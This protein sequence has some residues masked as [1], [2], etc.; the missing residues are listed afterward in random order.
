MKETKYLQRCWGTLNGTTA[1]SKGRNEV[2]FASK[3]GNNK[4]YKGRGWNPGLYPGGY[5]A[6]SV[7]VEKELQKKWVENSWRGRE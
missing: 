4:S 7:L 5:K 1:K 6:S 3:S 2:K